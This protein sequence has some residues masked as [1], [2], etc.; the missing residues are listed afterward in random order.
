[1][2]VLQKTGLTLYGLLAMA[3]LANS[4]I[5]EAQARPIDSLLVRKYLQFG[6]FHTVNS[7]PIVGGNNI[8][9]WDLG[10]GL[11]PNIPGYFV[12]WSHNGRVNEN[13]ANLINSQPNQSYKLFDLATMPSA[14][15]YKNQVLNYF[16]SIGIQVGIIESKRPEPKLYPNPVDRFTTLSSITQPN[17]EYS[18]LLYDASGRLIDQFKGF[19]NEQGLDFELD[20]LR[21]TKGI[22][23]IQF[24]NEDFLFSAKAIKK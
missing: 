15:F 11:S 7:H 20:F 5:T 18:I 12:A 21:Y 8:V 23:L 4:Q 16:V 9:T 6:N 2:R 22:Y 14:E 1:M 24:L 10:N 3:N 17:K 19:T 13:T